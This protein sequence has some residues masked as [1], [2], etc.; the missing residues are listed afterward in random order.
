[1]NYVIAS[2]NVKVSPVMRLALI[3]HHAPMVSSC[4]GTV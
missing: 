1:V 3:A 2:V 4:N